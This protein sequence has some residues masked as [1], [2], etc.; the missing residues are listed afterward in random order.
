[1]ID[2]EGQRD[3]EVLMLTVVQGDSPATARVIA[4]P[5]ATPA[6]TTA[7]PAI[8]RPTATQPVGADCEP[9]SRLGAAVPARAC[10]PGGNGPGPAASGGPAEP[11]PGGSGPGETASGARGPCGSGPGEAASGVAAAAGALGLYYE[12]LGIPCP[13]LRL[14]A[15]AT[16]R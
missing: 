4:H 2:G 10:R 6:S 13:Q 14:A 12:R 5:V 11:R 3:S 9:C 8:T 15:A 7:A 16:S 1:M